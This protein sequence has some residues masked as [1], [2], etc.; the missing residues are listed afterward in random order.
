[1]LLTVNDRNQTL[2]RKATKILAL[3]HSNL[4]GPTKPFTKDGYKYVFDFIDD[5]SGLMMLYFLK[6][7]S[8]TL[9]TTMKYLAD[10]APYGH[11]KC[12]WTDYGT[13]FTFELFQQLLVL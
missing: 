12:L 9:L 11:V 13:G 1:M 5:Y 2:D 6:H 3:V 7:K 4:V 10:I 8:N